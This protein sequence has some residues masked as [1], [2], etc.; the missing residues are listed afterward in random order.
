MPTI[1][2]GITEFTPTRA[3]HTGHRR[4]AGTRV[5]DVIAADVPSFSLAPASTRVGTLQVVCDDWA[6]AAQLD[7]MLARP[8]VFTYADP[9][10]AQLNVRFVPVDTYEFALDR[11]TQQLVVATIPYREVGS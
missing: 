7:A 10:A 9:A 2:D 8:A 11:V 6:H 3:Q 1:S 5:H 4:V